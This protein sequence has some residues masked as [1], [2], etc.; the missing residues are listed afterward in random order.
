MH[1]QDDDVVHLWDLP[2]SMPPCRLGGLALTRR[3]FSAWG[4]LKELKA[5]RALTRRELAS[6]TEERGDDEEEDGDLPSATTHLDVGPALAKPMPWPAR[7]S[8]GV[9]SWQVA[10]VRAGELR[11]LAR[12][13]AAEHESRMARSAAP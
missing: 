11:D 5:Q 1:L 12:L 6:I 2:A 3:Q 13:R 10:A 9:L 7:C 8:C 4:T